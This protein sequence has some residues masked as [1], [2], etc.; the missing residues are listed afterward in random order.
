MTRTAHPLLESGRSLAVTG[1]DM[2]LTSVR[3]TYVCVGGGSVIWALSKIMLL[4]SPCGGLP[5]GTALPYLMSIPFYMSLSVS[6]SPST[7]LCPWGHIHP[8]TLQ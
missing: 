7:S 6:P 4:L 2:N 3:D 5:Q 1:C 8:S